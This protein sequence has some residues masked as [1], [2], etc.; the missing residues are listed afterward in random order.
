MNDAS[1]GITLQLIFW[2]GRTMNDAS[3]GITLQLIF[4]QGRTMNDASVG[5]TLQKQPW[6]GRDGNRIRRKWRHVYGCTHFRH[7]QIY[8]RPHGLW[9]QLYA[10][11]RRTDAVKTSAHPPQPT[12]TYNFRSWKRKWLKGML[13]SAMYPYTVRNKID[14]SFVF[15]CLFVWILFMQFFF[16]FFFLL[17]PLQ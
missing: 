13:K 16:S 14:L 3:V 6:S 1:V 7:T 10:K 9:C 4:W 17:L 8:L 2:Q 11:V 15:V 12:N 5:I